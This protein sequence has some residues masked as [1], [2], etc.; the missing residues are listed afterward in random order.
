[1]NKYISKRYRNYS[2]KVKEM[3]D[4]I[5]NSVVGLETSF[6]VNINDYG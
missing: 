6:R 5:P 3:R 1:M 4:R 2:N